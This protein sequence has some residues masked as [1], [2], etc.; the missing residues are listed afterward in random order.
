[1]HVLPRI[2]NVVLAQAAL[3]EFVLFDVLLSE[4]DIAQSD[5]K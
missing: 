1:M 4:R 3:R 5:C 2:G